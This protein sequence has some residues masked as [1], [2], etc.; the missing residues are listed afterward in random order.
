MLELINLART[1]PAAMA[2]RVT[3]NLDADTL[4]TLNYYHV[5]LNQVKNIIASSPPKPPLAW[6]DLLAEAAQGQSQD[7]ANTGVQSHTGSDGSNLDTRLNRVGY[8]NRTTDGEN[9]YAYSKSIDQA[10]EAFLIDWGVAGNGHRDNLLQST[11]TPAQAYRDVGIGIVSTNR[12]GFGPLVITQDFGSQA[13]EKAELVG[14]VYDDPSHTHFY[15]PGE[16]RANVTINATNLATGQTTTTQTMDAG[17]YQMAL[18]PGNYRVTAL[19]GG[20]VVRSQT[21][22]VGTLNVK[23]DFDLS[24][25]WAAPAPVAS[26][27]PPQ[28]APAPAPTHSVPTLTFSAP[29]TASTAAATPTFN[30]AWITNWSSWKAV[31]V[32]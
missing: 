28:P 16:G 31:S 22:N 1:D 24:D 29:L 17:G 20:Q 25:P 7:Q 13:G 27:T 10:M 26:P 19:V 5:D 23:V 32:S 8:D 11:K 30:T 3:S 14:V 9:A 21:V 2:Q 18:D 12:P 4:D 6:N 15:A